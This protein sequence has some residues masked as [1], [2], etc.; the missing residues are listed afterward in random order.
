MN[1]VASSNHIHFPILTHQARFQNLTHC[2]ISQKYLIAF[3]TIRDMAQ[4]R[5]R[6]IVSVLPTESELTKPALL[7]EVLPPDL[8]ADLN[9][10]NECPFLEGPSSE[11]VQCVLIPRQIE[12]PN[13]LAAPVPVSIPSPPAPLFTALACFEVRLRT[14]TVCA[15]SI[16]ECRSG[17]S[18]GA[19]VRQGPFLRYGEILRQIPQN[20][21]AGVSFQLAM[22]DSD[23]ALG[24]FLRSQTRAAE[25]FCAAFIE[26]D[27]L[28]IRIVDIEIVSFRARAL[29]RI[30]VTD[31]NCPNIDNFVQ[32]L[33]S[34]F[35]MA[36]EIYS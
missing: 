13:C 17:A 30:R 7:S 15:V 3:N 33:I 20:E 10:P 14:A 12:P 24:E 4:F 29:L 27:C 5:L 11:V 34:V 8:I 9:L 22:F 18:A 23:G 35:F 36:V 26:R 32:K 28:S 6:R 21:C 1:D 25:R 2:L 31:V 16:Y 19:V